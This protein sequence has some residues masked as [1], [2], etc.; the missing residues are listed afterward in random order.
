MSKDDIVDPLPLPDRTRL[1]VLRDLLVFQL[2]LFVDGVKDLMLSP[3]SLVAGLIGIFL[4]RRPGEALY[5][6]LRFGK[7]MERWIDLFG[8]GYAERSN[9]ESEGIQDF[10]GMVDRFQQSL[11]DPKVRAR[12][13]EKSKN[14]I[15]SIAKKLRRGED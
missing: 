8:A 6:T 2:K 9:A 14:Q 4:S 3:V 15:D 13:S 7:R 11:L 12:L 5:R 1:Q 10:D